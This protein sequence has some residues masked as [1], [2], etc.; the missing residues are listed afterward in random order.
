MTPTGRYTMFVIDD[1]DESRY[2]RFVVGRREALAVCLCVH[3]RIGQKRNPSTLEDRP[4]LK[5]WIAS[6][7]NA[8][9]QVTAGSFN[10]ARPRSPRSRPAPP[11]QQDARP[12]PMPWRDNARRRYHD[13][14]GQAF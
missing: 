3:T 11:F 14:S 7:E 1:D 6:K 13:R 5:A 9:C 10:A 2:R 8:V 12:G 4:G